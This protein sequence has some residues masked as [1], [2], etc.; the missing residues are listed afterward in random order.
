MTKSTFT[1]SMYLFGFPSRGPRAPP[2][3]EE[4]GAG[5]E[6]KPR[7]SSLSRFSALNAII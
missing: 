5:A 6:A 7:V 1:R 2:G 3:G 4:A